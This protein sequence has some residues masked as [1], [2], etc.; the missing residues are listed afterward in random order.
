LEANAR[1][2]PL[3]FKEGKTLRIDTV[4]IAVKFGLTGLLFIWAWYPL[5]NGI[6]RD[7][8]FQADS[9]S[10][11]IW[12]YILGS[13]GF[14]FFRAIQK[15]KSSAPATSLTYRGGPPASISPRAISTAGRSRS[16][17]SQR[18]SGG[19]LTAAGAPVQ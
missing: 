12:T 16:T 4:S 17:R 15:A 10:L 6:Y 2:I 1:C 8:G 13:L 18:D 19:R 5:L 14:G 7:F 11:T 3:F 9:E